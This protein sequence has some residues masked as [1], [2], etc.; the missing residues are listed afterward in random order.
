MRFYMFVYLAV[1]LLVGGGMCLGLPFTSVSLDLP[2]LAGGAPV[3]TVGQVEAGLARDPEAWTDRTFLLRG[4]AIVA[5]CPHFV[6]I[7]GPLI[8]GGDRPPSMW[9]RLPLAAQVGPSGLAFLR[10]IPVLSSILPR[11]AVIRW[12]V[13]ATYRVHL[14]AAASASVRNAGFAV[15]LVDDVL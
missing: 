7:C 14:R 6:A 3:Y 1:A 9:D 13:P 15:V 4:T 8:V 11:A 2:V 10:R 12:D 5:E